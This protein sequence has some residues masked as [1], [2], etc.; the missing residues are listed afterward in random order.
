MEP[1]PSAFVIHRFVVRSVL[2]Q[3]WLSRGRPQLQ[4]SKCWWWHSL[5]SRSMQE[6]MLHHKDGSLGRW[7]LMFY[8]KV[9]H[10][11]CVP[12]ITQ[13][14]TSCTDLALFSPVLCAPPTLPRPDAMLSNL[15]CD[16]IADCQSRCCSPPGT[17]RCAASTHND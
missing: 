9:V 1:E 5:P 10:L 12:F 6:H 16:G 11:P 7:S 3:W 14:P 2:E 15:P 4:E 13:K 8:L 17:I